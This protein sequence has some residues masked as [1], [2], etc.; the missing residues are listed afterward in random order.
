MTETPALH[1]SRLPNASCSVCRFG[2][3]NESLSLCNTYTLSAARRNIDMAIPAQH[4]ICVPA[5]LASRGAEPSTDRHRLTRL[6]PPAW[7]RFG[8][9]RCVYFNAARLQSGAA[10]LRMEREP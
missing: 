7:R 1:A 4:G 6:S 10:S 5:P 9:R 3:C 2:I 8:H